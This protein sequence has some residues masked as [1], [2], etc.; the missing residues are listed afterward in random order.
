ML[1]YVTKKIRN[2]L[3]VVLC[4]G[5]L[6]ASVPCRAVAQETEIA[7][8]ASDVEQTKNYPEQKRALDKLASN[9]VE[10]A[11]AQ[12]AK[13]AAKHP[14]LSPAEVQLANVYTHVRQ[15]GTARM[16]LDR[17]LREDRELPDAY[18]ALGNID[19]LQGRKIEAE[20]L[21]EKAL[22]LIEQREIAPQRKTVLLASAR[23]TLGAIAMDY[24]RYEEAEKHFAAQS[25]LQ[26]ERGTPL[27]SL[28]RAQFW[29]K[30]GK[31]SFATLRKAVQLN[32]K[33]DPPSVQIAQFYVSQQDE[34]NALKWLE[35]A[36]KVGPGNVKSRLAM[37]RWHWGRG[38]AENCRKHIEAALVIDPDGHRAQLSMAALLHYESK[39]D[40]ASQLLEKV[41][42][43]HPNDIRA[44][45][46]LVL[47]LSATDN[48]ARQL[49]ALRRAQENFERHPN[50]LNVLATQ[51][52]L[53]SL[54][55]NAEEYQKIFKE[56][57]SRGYN[58][59]L[60]QF[61]A[62]MW[63]SRHERPDTARKILT[64]LL[65]QKGLFLF[66]RDAENLL[67]SLRGVS[68]DSE[69]PAQN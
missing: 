11:L 65:K 8:D 68:A 3:V 63:A 34:T 54:E 4:M 6:M 41:L 35:H 62:A 56:L 28:A 66:R 21:L 9:D 61:T 58:S 36:V 25:E 23:E 13:A 5:G 51:A 14:E 30:K 64:D 26:P 18:I 15:F 60:H 69:S 59:H 29:Q 7:Q 22:V 44:S 48:P 16:I 19:F 42:E 38:D 12:L 52:L 46:H 37:A 39:F 67:E 53:R 55:N 2:W 33:I 50:N 10:G 43:K 57:R 47:A 32:P 24:G 31:E 49:R 20:L 17:A 45:N 27:V 1:G 40:E